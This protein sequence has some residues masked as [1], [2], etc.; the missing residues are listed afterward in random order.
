[1]R[2]AQGQVPPGFNAL[3]AEKATLVVEAV[4]RAVVP[5]YGA[6]DQLKPVFEGT[7]VLVRLQDDFLLVSAAHVF[8]ALRRGVFLLL[9]GREKQPLLN[10]AVVNALEAGQRPHQDRIDIGFVRLTSEEADAAGRANFIEARPRVVPSEV[11]W[12]LRY[13]IL[14]YPAKAQVRLDDEGL[15]RPM[16]MP[17][18]APELKASEYVRVGLN[19]DEVIAID[20]NHRHIVDDLGRG[21]GRPD[22]V[23]LSGGGI[24]QFNPLERDLD[25]NPPALVGFLAAPAPR[26]GKAIFGATTTTLAQLARM[27]V[28]DDKLPAPGA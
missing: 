4:R 5:I 3:V 21:G 19:R 1:M 11:H 10:R 25:R 8:K 14:G 15:V 16:L 20:F 12:Y 24:W 6:D 27:P 26:H 2:D 28:D 17:Y 7:G 18:H 13:T 9:D 23:G 22:M